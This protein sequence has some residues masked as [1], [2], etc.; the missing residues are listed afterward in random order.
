VV[1]CVVAR[2]ELE[3]VGGVVGEGEIGDGVVVEVADRGAVDRR[4]LSDGMEAAGRERALVRRVVVDGEQSLGVLDEGELD[5]VLRGVRIEIDD[6]G[7]EAEGRLELRDGQAPEAGVEEVAAAVVD[8]QAVVQ[9]PA[10]RLADAGLGAV[11]VDEV[12]VGKAVAG[13]VARVELREARRD[14]SPPTV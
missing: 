9:V 7:V 2:A 14:R 4:E 12:E 5:D 10:R 13:D 1:E 11:V 6:L 8:Q 3:A